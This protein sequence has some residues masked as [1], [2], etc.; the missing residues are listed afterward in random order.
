M[1]ISCWSA[2]GGSGATVVAVALSLV[3]A[4]RAGPPVL[5]VDLAGDVPAVLGVPEP[6]GPGLAGWCRA[7]AD[8][9][10]DAL[11]RLEVRA[12]PALALLPRGDGAPGGAERLEV[13]ASLLAADGRV[14]VVDCGTLRLG[15]PATALAATATHSLLVTRPCYLA[16]RRAVAAPV[17]PS[18]VVLVD[19]PGRALDRHDVEAVLGVPVRAE[20]ALD[21]GVARAVDAG[22]LG[23]RLPRGLQRALRDAA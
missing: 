2:K 20:V 4:R 17:R 9:P 3:L 6:P 14:V 13:L 22:V 15:D 21:A 7:G 8:A 12:A 23:T 16:L 5:L 1:V 19:E 10:A 11:A 18:G